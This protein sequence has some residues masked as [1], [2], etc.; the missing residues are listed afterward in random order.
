[1][2]SQE[3]ASTDRISRVIFEHAA[4]ISREENL[5]AL[6]LLNADLARDLA[7]ADRCT[8]WLA[9]EDSRELW[10]RVA[11]GI[12]PIRIPMGRG[13]VGAC[14]A[15][16]RAI[17]V[18]DPASDPR[19]YPEVDGFSG[20][21][22]LSLLAV[23]LH[24]EG[25][26]IGA[27]QV[28]NKPGGFSESDVELLGLSA[29]Y[30]AAAIQAQR[31]RGEAEAARLLYHELEIAREVQQKLFPQNLPPV[32]GVEYAGVCVPAK[33]VGGDYY[34]FLDL[35]DGLFAFT[36]GDVSGKGISAAVLMASVQA[37]VRSQLLRA[38]LPV[39]SLMTELNKT[40]FHCSPEDKYTTLFCGMLDHERSTMTY[41]NAGQVLPMVL[42]ADES[43]PVFKPIES[44]FPIGL[45][46][47]WEYEEASID[48]HSGDVIVCFSDGISDVRNRRDEFWSEAAIQRVLLEHRR[49]PVE[50]IVESLI[51]G[52]N[53]FAAG[54]EQFDDMTAI[55]IR[56][57]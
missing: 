12:Q 54:A 9:D 46:E 4:K 28:L 48:L 36:I 41:V 30:A 53:E 15:G 43:K 40:V 47:V 14:V 18:N 38:P 22:T 29:T 39:S 57:K 35:S 17:V 44:G 11:H 2:E 26:V 1:M 55:A 42:R 52:A 16:N 5:D 6:L 13:V 21:H 8:I 37:L 31:L 50:R 32:R 45:S 49:S 3:T 20:Y 27:L 25:K 51:R 56:V 23:P 24:A 34:D 7:G 19:F 10:T 33:F